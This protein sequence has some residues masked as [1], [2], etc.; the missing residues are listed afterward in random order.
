VDGSPVPTKLGSTHRPETL[1][2]ALLQLL[3]TSPIDERSQS[4]IPVVWIN[5]DR[6]ERSRAKYLRQR[7]IVQRIADR[8]A[9][10]LT[11]ETR[12]QA[13]ESLRARADVDVVDLARVAAEIQGRE[14]ALLSEALGNM[15][16][17]RSDLKPSERERP[18]ASS[19][20]RSTAYGEPPP[21]RPPNRAAYDDTR[22]R[23]IE[24]LLA[25]CRRRGDALA[26][27]SDLLED[28]WTEE[29]T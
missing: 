21:K 7:A 28:L 9:D 2:R 16:T 5:V 11:P 8:G 6:R 23:E 17:W 15:A 1:A 27:E 26:Y 29:Q 4:P 13:I 22:L 12:R 14:D 20:T 19:Y 18:E 25:P 3:V 10:D 24:E